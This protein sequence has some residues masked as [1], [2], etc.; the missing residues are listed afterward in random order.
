MTMMNLTD[1][2]RDVCLER[3]RQIS[4]EGWTARHDDSHDEGDLALAA[5]CYAVA[6]DWGGGMTTATNYAKKIRDTILFLW[7]WDWSWWKATDRRRNLVKAGAL[8]IA[9]IERLDRKVECQ[10][11]TA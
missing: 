6:D 3:Q 5:A 10:R 9:E 1:A 11:E 2:M 4:K 8:I 7:P